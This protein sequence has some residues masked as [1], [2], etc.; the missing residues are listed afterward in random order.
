VA[1]VRLLLFAKAPQAGRVKTRLAAEVDAAGGAG[2][3]VAVDVARALLADALAAAVGLPGI[4]PVL[5]GSGDWSGVETGDVAR[6]EQGE[7][8][9]GDRV[10][11]MLAAGCDGADGALA[12]GAD[13]VAIDRAALID[14]ATRVRRGRPVLGRAEDGGFWLLGVPSCPQGLLE[15]VTW[16]APTTAEE[17]AARLD[18]AWGGHDEITVGW[19]LDRLADLE[20]VAREVDGLRARAPHLCA[21]AHGGSGS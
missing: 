10:A 7:G 8:G 13:T 20:R 12:V 5:A 19:D 15:G 14:A 6:W 1:R 18:A 4:E 17:T 11:R 16:S 2:V 21:W 3:A 9:L